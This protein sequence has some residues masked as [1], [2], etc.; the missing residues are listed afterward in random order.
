MTS[1]SSAHIDTA[2]KSFCT[3]VGGV[4]MN[5]HSDFDQKLIDSNALRWI[6]NNHSCIIATN[7]GRQSSNG[8]VEAH[9]TLSPQ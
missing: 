5:F 4:P 1:V 8:L 6:K 7:S 9:G 3:G 2:L